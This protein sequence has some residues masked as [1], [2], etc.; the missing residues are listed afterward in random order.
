MTTLLRKAGK[1]TLDVVACF[2]FCSL[3]DD[4]DGLGA[5]VYAKRVTETT[6]HLFD[7]SNSMM[8][9]YTRLKATIDDQ[10]Y[11]KI[12]ECAIPAKKLQKQPPSNAADKGKWL[13]DQLAPGLV[14]ENDEEKHFSALFA[15]DHKVMVFQEN[16]RTVLGDEAIA[17][18]SF[19]RVPD[20]KKAKATGGCDILQILEKAAERE[21]KI[22]KLREKFKKN[23][24]L[25][26]KEL[27][28][29]VDTRMKPFEAWREETLK[30]MIK[31][32][33]V[34][35]LLTLSTRLGPYLI[36][37]MATKLPPAGK[38]LF[39][40][41]WS[42]IAF[43]TLS[44]LESMEPN[45]F[46]AKRYLSN[47]LADWLLSKDDDEYQELTED[48]V[49]E[50]KEMQETVKLLLAD[51]EQ[52]QVWAGG[53]LSD[54]HQLMSSMIFQLNRPVAE[55]IVFQYSLL[56]TLLL[57]LKPIP[58][59]LI[60]M[61]TYASYRQFRE[62]QDRC[63]Y[64]LPPIESFLSSCC[65]SLSTQV[66]YAVGRFPLIMIAYNFY[67]N[68]EA[69][70]RRQRVQWE[71]PP[72][73]S[74]TY[75]MLQALGIFL[76]RNMYT[77]SKANFDSESSSKIPDE[78]VTKLQDIFSTDY[79]SDT[80]KRKI[81][82]EDMLDLAVAVDHYMT[83]NE[84]KTG[85]PPHVP[86]FWMDRKYLESW[87]CNYSLMRHRVVTGEEHSD[88]TF[89][90]E[91]LPEQIDYCLDTFQF[92]MAVNIVKPI[93]EKGASAMDIKY[94]LFF[95]KLVSP[96]LDLDDM[97][98][99]LARQDEMRLEEFLDLMQ[100]MY[101][102]LG[103]GMEI[104]IP[105]Y[106]PKIY[107]IFEQALAGRR[108]TMQ[109]IALYNMLL[110]K[111]ISLGQLRHRSHFYLSH[112]I[113]WHRYNQLYRKFSTQS[114]EVDRLRIAWENYFK[115]PKYKDRLIS[116]IPNVDSDKDKQR[117]VKYIRLNLPPLDR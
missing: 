30:S 77:T 107:S 93:F 24:G 67:T 90:S 72:E 4:W 86:I 74:E 39:R 105:L 66:L 85:A 11:Q 34:I 25:I 84:S 71:H 79:Y 49:V 108:P 70:R 22:D 52:P 8:V 31:P 96:T 32:M 69:R 64:A 40:L 18:T 89:T 16:Y 23:F 27:Q 44:L 9:E 59:H 54:P 35:A 3:V 42:F 29:R 6:T 112:G 68:G 80:D 10:L 56:S 62:D 83:T 28:L 33:G 113:T 63:F 5:E 91:T 38:F 99:A 75:Q 116:L 109:E 95:C 76:M 58:A 50:H 15:P 57:Y 2:S 13:L 20:N 117:L 73:Q 98:Q 92:T 47:A 103:Q 45:S 111:I 19:T 48:D 26:D 60:V 21:K 61:L 55:T 7:Q 110:D 65:A 46:L 41:F 97:V 17:L 53:S 36:P 94:F 1:V 14:K 104:F 87:I 81:S 12:S 51:P 114:K 78:I 100:S 43:G 88:K 82:W 37:S 101:E 106:E 115:S 102:E